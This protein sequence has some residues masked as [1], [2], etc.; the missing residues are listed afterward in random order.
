MVIVGSLTSVSRMTF[1]SPCGGNSRSGPMSLV[2]PAAPFGHTFNSMRSAA[3]R[4][5]ETAMS[6]DTMQMMGKVIDFM[7][8]SFFQR[9]VALMETLLIRFQAAGKQNGLLHFVIVR[10]GKVGIFFVSN[11]SGKVGGVIDIAGVLGKTSFLI[12]FAEAIMRL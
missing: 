12:T 5:F 1:F 4:L 11:D 3:D 8:W 9:L 2:S 7:G 6:S 10:V